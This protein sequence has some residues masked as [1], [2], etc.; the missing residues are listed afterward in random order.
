MRYDRYRLAGL[1]PAFI[2]RWF[3]LPRSENGVSGIAQGSG[4]RCIRPRRSLYPFTG[5]KRSLVQS[6]V[7]MEKPCSALLDAFSTK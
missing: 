6:A 7:S 1:A 4:I 2:A 3:C 5:P